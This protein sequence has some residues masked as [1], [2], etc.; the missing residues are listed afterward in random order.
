MIHHNCTA[1][2]QAN[3]VRKVK[4]SRVQAQ[5]SQEGQMSVEFKA[6]DV[7]KVKVIGQE[8]HKNLCTNS[9]LRINYMKMAF[10]K[11][12]FNSSFWWLKNS[13]V[14][15]W[16][17]FKCNTKPKHT[18]LFF[19][20]PKV[21]KYYALGRYLILIARFEKGNNFISIWHNAVVP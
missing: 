1:E 9:V 12:I 3:E 19:L 5:Q 16:R 2:F 11:V 10:W 17:I 13:I 4:V 6:N 18:N 7:R 21:W 8:V 15:K 14:G 20:E